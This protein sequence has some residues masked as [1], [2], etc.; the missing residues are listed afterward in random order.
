VK[1]HEDADIKA[2]VSEVKGGKCLS[3]ESLVTLIEKRSGMSDCSRG[4]ILDGLPLNKRQCELL[5]KKGIVPTLLLSLKMT[6]LD[7]KKRVQKIN[8]PEYD[9]YS[10][11]VHD[12]LEATRKSLIEI[13][14]YYTNKYNNVRVIEGHLSKWGI[15]EQARAEI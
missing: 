8:E 14:I 1:E 2:I 4:W 11:V 3:D 10:E 6:E 13:E 15:F 9:Y 12:R 7:I 5:N